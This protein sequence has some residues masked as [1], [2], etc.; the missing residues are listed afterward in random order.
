[1]N[2]TDTIAAVASATGDSARGIVRVSGEKCFDIVRHAL[3]VNI[4]H[5]SARYS[6][7]ETFIHVDELQLPATLYLM[8]APCSYTREDTAEVHTIGNQLVLAKVMER[9]IRCGAR[10]ARPGEFTRRAFLNGRIDLLQAE[11]VLHLVRA[12]SD[13]FRKKAMRTASGELSRTI[14]RVTTAMRNA[15]SSLEALIEFEEDGTEAEGLETIRE[16]LRETLRT[17]PEPSPLM[18]AEHASSGG[19]TVVME[20]PTN[21]GKSTLFNTLCGKKKALVSRTRC[22]TRDWLS[23]RVVVG[24]IAVTLIDTAGYTDDPPGEIDRLSVEKAQRLRES[25]HLRLL[26]LDG[27]SAEAHLSAMETTEHNRLVVI[28]KADLLS[29]EDTNALRGRL[30]AEG[31]DFVVVSALT[32]N[33]VEQLKRRIEEKIVKENPPPGVP[34]VLLTARQVEKLTDARNH[35]ETAL[36]L[37]PDCLDLIGEELRE[38]ITALME[39]QGHTLAEQTLD[40]IFERFCVGK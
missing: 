36:Q 14:E 4:P 25:A 37:P 3:S 28:N 27:T 30:Q 24:N 19:I 22:T 2:E 18:E 5:K 32:G 16:T 8:P 1:M 21:A 11:S 34:D 26:V 38:A 40:D 12:S 39:L 29:K 6:S 31:L 17:L 23:C 7:M 20:G 15:Y 13:W 33:G 9:L 35:M 10:V